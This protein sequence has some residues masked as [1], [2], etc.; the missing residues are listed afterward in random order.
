MY[1]GNHMTTGGWI[2]SI[3]GTLIIIALIAAAIVWLIGDRSRQSAPGASAREI[4]DRR[5]ANG[6]LDLEQYKQLRAE[7][8]DD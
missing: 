7:L 8:T 2:F 4:L 3:V 5:L 1:W 6:E